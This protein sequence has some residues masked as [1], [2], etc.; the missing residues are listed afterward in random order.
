M[1]CE[2]FV[3]KVPASQSTQRREGKRKKRVVDQFFFFFFFKC[4]HRI[5]VSWQIILSDV[6]L[7]FCPISDMYL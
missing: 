5:Y 4:P 1:E 3:S 6:N 2:V 7:T